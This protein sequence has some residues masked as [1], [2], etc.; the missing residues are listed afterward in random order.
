MSEYSDAL[1]RGDYDGARHGYRRIC[2]GCTNV[3]CVCKGKLAPPIEPERNSDLS[4]EERVRFRIAELRGEPFV[5]PPT[6]PPEEW[7]DE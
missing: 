5:L 7:R 3:Y 2:H 6:V 1:A 4:F